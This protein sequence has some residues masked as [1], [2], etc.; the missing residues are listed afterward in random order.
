M[1]QGCSYIVAAGEDVLLKSVCLQ[2]TPWD[3]FGT[4]CLSSLTRPESL[5]ESSVNPGAAKDYPYLMHLDPTGV[6]EPTKVGQIVTSVSS[7]A[8]SVG[9]IA[10]VDRS[11]LEVSH[12]PSP[13]LAQHPC[14]ARAECVLAL[15]LPWRSAW[16]DL[17]YEVWPELKTLG[18]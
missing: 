3:C 4:S 5:A 8:G 13:Y 14:L 16:K 2:T 1:N 10:I 17:H 11:Q 7:E 18:V 9:R 12:H 6:I 15:I